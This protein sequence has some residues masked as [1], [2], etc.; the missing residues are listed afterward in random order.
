MKKKFLS[1]ILIICLLFTLVPLETFAATKYDI[2]INDFQFTSDKLTYTS[3]EGGTASYSPTTNTLT[4]TNFTITSGDYLSTIDVEIKDVKIKLVGTNKIII[5]DTINDTFVIGLNLPYGG[6]I[7]GDGSSKSILNIVSTSKGSSKSISFGEDSFNRVGIYSQSELL[8]VDMVELSMTDNSTK[9]YLGASALILSD[10]NFTADRAVFSGKNLYYGLGVRFGTMMITYTGFDLSS[11]VNRSIGIFNSSSDYNMISASSGNISGNA[12]AI[13]NGGNLN[14]YDN[15]LT[16]SSEKTG[17]GL[18]STEKNS[19]TTTISGGTMNLSAPY[20][21]C[22]YDNS[23]LNVI[24]NANIDI[25]NS[26]VGIDVMDKSNVYLNSGTVNVNGAGDSAIRVNSSSAVHLSGAN[27]KATGLSSKGIGVDNGASFEHENGSLTLEGNSTSDSVGI[28]ANGNVNLSGGTIDMSDVDYGIYSNSSSKLLVSGGKQTISANTVGYEE[29]SSGVLNIKND[30]DM[31]INA[32]IGADFT[33]SGSKLLMEGGKLTLNVTSTGLKLGGSAGKTTISSGTLNVTDTN[34]KSAVNGIDAAGEMEIS[35]SANVTFTNNSIDIRT[36]NSKNKISGGTVNLSGSSQGLFALSDFEISGGNVKSNCLGYGIVGYSG[37]IKFSGGTVTMN[38]KDYSLLPYKNASFEFCGAN[39][40]ATSEAQVALILGNTSDCSYSITGGSVTLKGAVAAAGS[41]YTGN[42]PDGY[43]V[44]AGTDSDHTDIVSSPSL[45]TFV[46]NKYIKIAKNIKYNLTLENVK[47][48]SSASHFAGEKISYTAADATSG[49]HFDHWELK[50]GS[51]AAV[52]AGSDKTYTGAMPADNAVLKAV[53]ADCTYMEQADS[54][55]LKSPADC[56]HGNI[57]YKSCSVCKVSSKGTTAEAYFD[58]G[59]KTGHAWSKLSSNGDGTHSRSCSYYPDTHKETNLCYGGTEDDKH[60]AVCEGCGGKYEVK[61]DIQSVVNRGGTVVLSENIKLDS[62]LIISNKVTIDLNGYTIDADNKFRIMEITDAGELTLTDS[63]A[64][65]SG[66]LTNG[67]ADIGGGILVNGKLNLEA[68]TITNCISTGKG[69]GM[70]LDGNA[71]VNMS[72]GTI[73]NCS[74]PTSYG[75]GVYLNSGVFNMSSGNIKGCSAKDFG[76]GVCV[77]NA[78]FDMS[79]GSITNCTVE[80]NGGGIQ[81]SVSGTITL[82][83]TAVIKDCKATSTPESNAIKNN[84]IFNANGGEVYGTVY[85]ADTATITGTGS[86]TTE[87]YGDLTGNNAVVKAGIYYSSKPKGRIDGYLITFKKDA[88]TVYAYEAV[89]SGAKVIEPKTPTVES[90][91]PIWYN[92]N[93]QFDFNSVVNQ[94]LTLMLGIETHDLIVTGSGIKENTDYKYD[95]NR[96]VILTSKAMTIKN[97]DPTK[98]VSMQIYIE[99]DVNANITLAGVNIDFSTTGDYTLSSKSGIAAFLIANNSKGNVNIMLEDDTENVLASGTWKA[100]IEKNGGGDDVGTL[101]INGN[102]GS[103]T[104]ISIRGGAAIGSAYNNETKNIKI[105][106]GVINA[107]TE[108]NGAGVGCGWK[109]RAYNITISGGIVNAISDDG[110]GIGSGEAGNV[111]GIN[112]T[113]GVIYAKSGRW[114]AGIGGGYKASASDIK[115]SGGT[116]TAYALS[117]DISVIDSIGAGKDGTASGLIINGGSVYAYSGSSGGYSITY[118]RIIT[119]YNEKGERVYLLTISNPDGKKVYVDGIEYNPVNH[120]AQDKNN[121]KLYMYLLGE[122][123]TVQIGDKITHY[124]FADGVFK[125]ATY[126]D[127]YS[128]DNNYHWNVC[129]SDNCS[130]IT[131]YDKHSIENGKCNICEFEAVYD[132]EYDSGPLVGLA[133]ASKKWNDKLLEGINVPDNPGYVFGGWWTSDNIQVTDDMTYGD[134]VG[135]DTIKSISIKIKWIIPDAP[136][137]SGITDGATYYTSQKISVTGDYIESITLNGEAV[138]SDFVLPGNTEAEYIIVA[139]NKAGISTTYVISMH[140]LS[141]ITGVADA[142]TEK[143]V[144]ENDRASLEEIKNKTATLLN[145]VNISD[146]EKAIL[147]ASLK[148]IDELLTLIDNI[149]EQSAKF[150]R[151]DVNRDG[152]INSQDALL[153]LQ[154]SAKLINCIYDENEFMRNELFIAACD[155]NGDS[156]VDA[157]DALEILKYAAKLINE[158][159]ASS[160]LS[161]EEIR[162]LNAAK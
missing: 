14:L 4:L 22:V 130:E 33:G 47:E 103:L 32:P 112:I 133:R 121:I 90:G 111:E 154:Y 114:G 89:A 150:V 36:S 70:Y 102:T 119:P 159:Q 85:N 9:N 128:Y 123:H 3:K 54:N 151:G 107:T 155:T 55:C 125:E 92:G 41:I 53:Y 141:D 126:S 2:L 50:I 82:S 109:G 113:G 59:N 43:S 42:L 137:I 15:V 40:N 99:A 79:G 30:A 160:S 127:K 139:T 157:A 144:T 21:I 69:G 115:I 134:V 100:G 31:T 135:D 132:V 116:V 149:S 101:T 136:V 129:N 74:A 29:L 13:S 138:E 12:A 66:K 61:H 75:G 38:D 23:K 10:N 71:T 72:G 91:S 162:D 106:G 39:V 156:A 51:A 153:V 94:N 67:A 108:G 158:F 44:W 120:S 56:E 73:S 118:D 5:P 18:F 78:L 161:F 122:T 145:D 25:N 80:T 58:D 68:G 131:N 140:E 7:I 52:N 48:G 8:Y 83:G 37:K 104:V 98:A 64:D 11:N 124:H 24:N 95:G 117:P 20:G 16:L 97:Q 62:I 147:N 1:I 146:E 60:M 49:K 45:N 27:I 110:A 6:S 63:S 142:M 87:F 143:D 77:N 28:Y 26:S 148:H 17:L 65:K 76:G 96:L 88:N 81:S 57:Y 34:T 152:V 84:Y 35:G 19:Y 86:K 46:G 93:T 105:L